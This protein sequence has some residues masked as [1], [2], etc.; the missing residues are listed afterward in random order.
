MFWQTLKWNQIITVS[1]LNVTGI[2]K[3]NLRIFGGG[4]IA[5]ILLNDR[6][7]GRMDFPLQHHIFA[8][9]RHVSSAFLFSLLSDG[10]SL[11]GFVAQ[12]SRLLSCSQ[13]F[14]TC[15]SR[16]SKPECWWWWRLP[17][18][19]WW[20]SKSGSLPNTTPIVHHSVDTHSW[21]ARCSSLGSP[22]IVWLVYTT[23]MLHSADI[24]SSWCWIS[25]H[26]ESCLEQESKS[27]PP[28]L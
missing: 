27:A 19:T 7:Y 23:N 1:Y 8:W 15:S 11:H 28:W 2:N 21:G 13:L 10:S 3:I 16:S 9:S 18:L 26:R 12:P 24:Q 22:S 25:R 5:E 20:W 14:H 17:A 6:P 4:I